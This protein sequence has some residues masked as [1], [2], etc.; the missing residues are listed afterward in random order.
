M[1]KQ[2]SGPGY[3]YQ[4]AHGATALAEAWDAGPSSSQNHA[5]LGHAEEWLYRGLGGLNPDPGGPGFKKFVV[6]P[7]P[8]TGLA[9]VDVQYHSVRGQIAVSWQ[10]Q[11]APG[12]TRLTISVTVPVNTTATV[13]VPTTDPS[14][15]TEGGRPVASVSGIASMPAVAGAAVLVVGSGHYVFAAP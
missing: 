1:L 6:K 7:Q 12:P 3:L 10:Q 13:Y 5:M 15:V 9:S 11:A 2:S 14:A 8:Q 4:I